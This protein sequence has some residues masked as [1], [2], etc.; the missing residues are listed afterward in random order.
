MVKTTLL[1]TFGITQ[2]QWGNPFGNRQGANTPI[3]TA[4]CKWL[5]WGAWA[6]CRGVCGSGVQ[7]RVRRCLG[8]IAGSCCQG[9]TLDSK[10]CSNPTDDTCSYW[11]GWGQWS[12]ASQTCGTAERCK[13]R[14][15]YGRDT[16]HCLG[17]TQICEAVN[18]KEPEKRQICDSCSAKCCPYDQ[19][20][21]G[22]VQCYTYDDCSPNVKIP[23]TTKACD[24]QPACC[25]E[26]TVF[27]PW[28]APTKSCF[29][30][31]VKRSRYNVCN[32]AQIETEAK[33]LELGEGNFGPWQIADGCNGIILDGNTQCPGQ[34]RYTR[35]HSCYGPY[36]KQDRAGNSL[37]FNKVEACGAL[38]ATVMSDFDR[39]EADCAKICA[40]AGIFKVRKEIQPC[41]G[42][43]VNT[44][45]VVCGVAG[46]WSPFSEWTECDNS[47]GGKQWRW[48]SHSCEKN[49]NQIK[50]NYESRACGGPTPWSEFGEW[51]N[52]CSAEYPAA[53][54]DQTMYRKRYNVCGKLDV[55]TNNM[56]Y[57]QTETAACAKP[58]MPAPIVTVSECSKSCVQAGEVSLRVQTTNQFCVADIV[59]SIPC[60]VPACCNWLP[61]SEW[62]ACDCTGKQIQTKANS[63]KE[64][65]ALTYVQD[66][67][68]PLEPYQGFSDWS[69]CSNVQC[70]EQ[71]FR[72]RFSCPL[73]AENVQT[74][75]AAKIERSACLGKNPVETI[76][77]ACVGSCNRV[78]SKTVFEQDVC[79]K[80]KFNER[81]VA[82]NIP[83][84]DNR[85]WGAYTPCKH[86][87]NIKLCPGT[88][89]RYL[90]AFVDA[91]TRET[92][93]V[94]ESETV[95]CGPQKVPENKF[96]EWSVCTATNCL[97]TRTEYNEC[98]G[99]NQ[100]ESQACDL[101][102][103]DFSLW[104][105]CQ[106]ETYGLSTQYICRGDS[107]RVRKHICGRYNNEVETRSCG[108]ETDLATEVD[109]TEL[110]FFTS[111]YH[112]FAEPKN[113]V[114][115]SLWS[116]CPAN[117]ENPTGIQMITRRSVCPTKW[118]DVTISK[119]C[120]IS[121]DSCLYCGPAQWDDWTTCSSDC[122]LG[123]Q[124]RRQFRLC[125][126]TATKKEWRE[127]LEGAETKNCGARRSEV[128]TYN[129][130]TS[131]N[132]CG[133]GV[134]CGE[135]TRVLTIT[136]VS[137][138]I[139]CPAAKK[140]VILDT[141]VE[142]CP[143]PACPTWTPFVGEQCGIC[144]TK[145]TLS[146]YCQK[147]IGAETCE[148]A[149]GAGAVDEA[150]IPGPSVD[151]QPFSDWSAC[152]A[153]CGPG[154]QFRNRAKVCDSNNIDT[155]TRECNVDAGR[156]VVLVA[157]YNGAVQMS[158]VTA[159]A[160]WSAC[161]ST[162]CVIGQ[163]T[164]TLQHTCYGQQQVETQ[165]CRPALYPN[166]GTFEDQVWTQ[167]TGCSQTCGDGLTTWSR[168]H[169]CKKYN[170]F[171]DETR[172]VKC[173][174]APASPGA[175]D[176]WA[177]CSKCYTDVN[178][179][180]TTSRS[181]QWSCSGYGTQF[182]G[183]NGVE[184]ETATCQIPSCAYLSEWSYVPCS[185][186]RRN[187]GY[188]TRQCIN[189]NSMLGL[190]CG[191]APLTEQLSC[192]AVELQNLTFDNGY[193]IVVEDWQPW[194]TC[195]KTCDFSGYCGVT[196]RFQRT[197]CMDNSADSPYLEP[198][199][200]REQQN[201]PCATGTYGEI[202]WGA[203]SAS[204]AS[205]CLGVQTGVK[206]HNCGGP[207][208]SESRP[209]GVGGTWSQ[210][211]DY[212]Q[213]T[214]SCGGGSKSRSRSWTC[215]S[216]LRQDQVETVQCNNQPC[217][218]LG[219]WSN[220][221]ACS[222]SCGVGSMSRSRYCHGGGVGTGLCQADEQGVV[223]Q[224]T[225]NCNM[226]QCCEWDWSGWTGCCLDS[227]KVERQN[228]RLRFRGNNCGS[229]WE[230]KEKTCEHRPIPDPAQTD[231]PSCASITNNSE[232]M[233]QN[234][235]VA[236]KWLNFVNPDKKK[237]GVF[238]APV[239][240][241]ADDPNVATLSTAYTMHINSDTVKYNSAPM[242][243][244]VNEPV[245]SIYQPGAGFVMPP[246]AYNVV[247][248]PVVTSNLPAG[249]P[250]GYAP[251]SSNNSNVYT[252]TQDVPQNVQTM[253]HAD[254]FGTGFNYLSK[255]NMNHG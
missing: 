181:R 112:Y 98:T 205:T 189:A 185:C 28:S 225:A 200:A 236:T 190:D 170:N 169:S 76:E 59:E 58:V 230:V 252:K 255:V 209:C 68:K 7:T 74:C 123:H 4:T 85:V 193:Q 221:G 153:T 102:W 9:N 103:T 150:C 182:A 44:E 11:S 39:S 179:I 34:L 56:I 195:G 244:Q 126:N 36:D 113:A 242:R 176:A 84:D 46:A 132:A 235:N 254:P 96:T 71:G 47:C 110:T 222:V 33:S 172:Y 164:R 237:S 86:D 117:C 81:Q 41:T 42:A 231:F 3:D 31:T 158:D 203:C 171:E 43:V 152:S 120:S 27:G 159:S 145:R 220:W 167:I 26:W 100:I 204:D 188:R 111:V 127:E 15:C 201:C 87:R 49:G 23:T 69:I 67:V 243:P 92:C 146:R 224:D 175:W 37:V 94:A 147:T 108:I 32:K 198:Q 227:S 122:D 161:S 21:C 247:T 142:S 234:T 248:T 1:F 160:G 54:A 148:C 19:P 93:A 13:T 226:G 60:V 178:A 12:A 239:L 163:Q 125:R 140:S 157:G 50:F 17:P 149:A 138:M 192:D 80:L 250:S 63:C 97:Q 180:P 212:A 70:P 53:C 137:S 51:S 215:A 135:G 207:A 22:I 118:K 229:D 35:T 191:G 249:L 232:R 18:N 62:S 196:E 72:L 177:T 99:F 199:I 91:N 251:Q 89:S 129:D 156:W 48:Q 20:N 241:H 10:G 238:M 65:A 194:A 75:A 90:P 8:G 5:P 73:C 25:D 79:T 82:C 168:P 128:T 186:A 38:P 116:A 106:A 131:A 64:I 61:A 154:T 2:A 30:D 143:L 124:H 29:T 183:S 162:E 101:G 240:G 83:V 155:E 144:D 228:I 121:T 115:E 214:A 57:E 119:Q 105:P 253:A 173:Q 104:S 107:T 133:P 66:C 223:L 40:N 45:A 24:P 219:A 217:N 216:D 114:G 130:C 136:A 52:T 6:E 55:S 139:T 109:L 246:A 213:C 245:Q 184:I 211:S 206:T 218:Y 197:L 166:G 88:K 233:V 14:T 95:S 187:G 165:E 208:L 210:W 134:F 78:G 151:F 16:D 141:S 174:N 202:Q 77:G